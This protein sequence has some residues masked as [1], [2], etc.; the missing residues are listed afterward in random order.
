MTEAVPPVRTAL[1]QT[2]GVDL[3]AL[4]V[5]LTLALMAASQ[6][7]RMEITLADPRVLKVG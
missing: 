7:D 3:P 1:S 4:R 2:E 5:V 6:P